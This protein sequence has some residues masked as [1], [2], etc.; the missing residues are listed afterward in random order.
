MDLSTKASTTYSEASKSTA[1]SLKKEE[2]YKSES[3]L[4]KASSID[5]MMPRILNN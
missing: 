2:E 5:Y 3:K 1:E 4:S